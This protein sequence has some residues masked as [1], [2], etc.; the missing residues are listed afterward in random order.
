VISVTAFLTIEMIGAAVLALWV[1]VRFPRLG[2]KSLRSALAF[3]A[4]GFLVMQLTSFGVGM[5]VRLPYGTYAALFGCALPCF[6]VVFLAAAWL[7]RVLAGSLGG[8]GGPD[9]GHRVPAHARN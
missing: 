9:S 8:S 3:V 6:F 2:P 1:I 5:L 7:M 4:V